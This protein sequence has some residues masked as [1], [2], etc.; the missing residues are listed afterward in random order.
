[1]GTR[2]GALTI[3]RPA[4]HTAEMRTGA[5]GDLVA[6][7]R[8][9]EAVPLR[10]VV[11]LVHGLGEHSGRYRETAAEL[12][13]GGFATLGYDLQGHGRSPGPRG[14]IEDYDAVLDDIAAALDHAV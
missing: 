9:P 10:A 13:R 5:R 11:V 4:D 12:A 8:R 7:I 6:W 14:V 2:T 1:R 3:D